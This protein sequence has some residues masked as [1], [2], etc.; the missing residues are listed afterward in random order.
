MV[1]AAY[2]LV[3][4]SLQRSKLSD[5]Y[6]LN[7]SES[8]N[9]RWP[10]WRLPHW[11]ATPFDQQQWLVVSSGAR[12]EAQLAAVVRRQM[13]DAALRVLPYA[14]GCEYAAMQQ[15]S[16][17]MIPLFATALL[18]VGCEGERVDTSNRDDWYLARY[19]VNGEAAPQAG[20]PRDPIQLMPFAGVVVNANSITIDDTAYAAQMEAVGDVVGI[21]LV[22]HGDD[23]DFE[24]HRRGDQL[25]LV[26]HETGEEMLLQLHQK[27]WRRHNESDD[28]F[29]RLC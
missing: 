26:N 17:W 13:F 10:V 2:H 23:R 3:D 27:I 11:L 16:P 20:D 28:R 22:D 1:T 14:S 24:L 12:L 29:V 5:H 4:Q 21:D 15:R 19:Q 18:I 8:A 25:W 9:H 6:T 7:V